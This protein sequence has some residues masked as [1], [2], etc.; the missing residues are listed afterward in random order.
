MVTAEHAV[1]PDGTEREIWFPDP[2]GELHTFTVDEWCY[3]PGDLAVA[4][5]RPGFE[6]W[7]ALP[8]NHLTTFFL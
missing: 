1:P 6:G 7:A 5:F 8:M 3:G 4:P 2:A